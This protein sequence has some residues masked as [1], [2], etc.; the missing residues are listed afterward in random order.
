MKSEWLV[1]HQVTSTARPKRPTG[2]ASDRGRFCRVMF[3]SKSAQTFGGPLGELQSDSWQGRSKPSSAVELGTKA[4]QPG[5]RLTRLEDVDFDQFPL[6]WSNCNKLL[7]GSFLPLSRGRSSSQS[8]K[9]AWSGQS[10]KGPSQTL[11]ILFT[12]AKG[13]AAAGSPASGFASSSTWPGRLAKCEGGLRVDGETFQPIGQYFRF[14]LPF[15]VGL[16]GNPKEI[17]QFGGRRF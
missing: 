1:K 3:H 12:P 7:V 16:E 9:V 2:S 15:G 11:H 6:G 10:A 8:S 17:T 14:C 13:R 5:N 4:S